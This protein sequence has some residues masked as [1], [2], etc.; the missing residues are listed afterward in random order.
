MFNLLC[1]SEANRT[2]TGSRHLASLKS[3]NELMIKTCF[4]HCNRAP[5]KGNRK[6]STPDMI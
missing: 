4:N 2:Q 5:W 1:V 3:E 6:M